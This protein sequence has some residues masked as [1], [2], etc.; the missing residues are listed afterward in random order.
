[1]N[2]LSPTSCKQSTSGKSFYTQSQQ[3]SSPKRYLTS[4]I[5]TFCLLFWAEDGAFCQTVT[6]AGLV[7]MGGN[8]TTAEAGSV[9]SSYGLTFNNVL[10]G[11]SEGLQ[12]AQV[13]NTRDTLLLTTDEVAAQGL[14][15]G[16]V[17]PDNDA[18]LGYT[19][20]GYDSYAQH[21]VYE[22]QCP[23]NVSETMT[24]SGQTTMD[25]TLEEPVVA[26]TPF[27]GVIALATPA[28]NPFAYP[29][30]ETEAQWNIAVGDQSRN[31]PL[32][33]NI[34]QML[35]PA[36]V[37]DIDDN[38]YNVVSIAPYCW[39]GKNMAAVRYSDGTD[40]PGVMVYPQG[41]YTYD[42]ANTF[43]R[44]YTWPAA[45]NNGATNAA[46]FVQ[47]ICPDGWH[48]PTQTEAE[49]LMSAVEPTDLM[50]PDYWLPQGGTN[51]TDFGELPAGFYNAESGYYEGL[52]VKSY[53]WTTEPAGTTHIACEFGAACGTLVATP[54][55][56]ASGLSVRCVLDY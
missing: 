3:A 21:F 6:S 55:H 17:S 54:A 7:P 14:Q 51:A 25:V 10:G 1:M 42:M 13:E 15:I 32:K 16:Y 2:I 29:I 24:V 40:I 47:G 52:L 28:S 36:T 12:Q 50:T 26:P 56:S 39:T 23:D 19:A 44:L 49:H 33:V 46:G 38:V 22:Y 34:M 11:L 27:D 4:I 9:A 5:F 35:C 18:F 41:A 53:F 30:G 20:E 31:C 43:G 37:S 8:A 45:A 48:L